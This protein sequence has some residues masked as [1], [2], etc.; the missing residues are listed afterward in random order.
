[1]TSAEMSSRQRGIVVAAGC[2]NIERSLCKTLSRLCPG[3]CLVPAGKG[4]MHDR[5]SELRPA[6]AFVDAALIDESMAKLLSTFEQLVLF[7][8]VGA[9]EAARRFR[10]PIK[11]G[12]FVHFEEHWLTADLLLEL[13]EKELTEREDVPTGFTPSRV[14][15]VRE[16]HLSPLYDAQRLIGPRLT[17]FLS[18]IRGEIRQDSGRLEH[19][20]VETTSSVE[21]PSTQ[22]LLSQNP[23][24]I[25]EALNEICQFARDPHS[26]GRCF[27]L[28]GK[29]G[30]GKSTLSYHAGAIEERLK[31]VYCVG[32]DYS[33]V[34]SDQILKGS[35]VPLVRSFARVVDAGLFDKAAREHPHHLAIDA[36]RVVREIV[37]GEDFSAIRE[38]PE[39]TL[40]ILH[41]E[42]DS[43]FLAKMYCYYMHSGSRPE[44]IA[45]QHEEQARLIRTAQDWYHG[46]ARSPRKLFAYYLNFVLS[47]ETVENLE[48]STF[49][50][51]VH[52]LLT[53]AGNKE[54]TIESIG[55]SLRKLGLEDPVLE[56]ALHQQQPGRISSCMFD[57]SPKHARVIALEA[58]QRMSRGLNPLILLDNI[59]QRPSA[60]LEA[61]VVAGAITLFR[62]HINE[63]FPDSRA[64]V[65]MRDSTY[66]Q[67]QWIRI[68][69][70][71]H[72]PMKEVRPP[73]LI[74]VLDKRCETWRQTA[75]HVG[76][77]R[78]YEFA[79][80]VIDWVKGW[81]R[82]R[83]AS[84]AES[85]EDPP[86]IDIIEARYPFNVGD[87]LSAFTK[88]CRNA[89]LHKASI[90]DASRK[91]N[92][93]PV[94]SEKS[95][96]FFLR[97]FLLA[98]R[99]YFHEEYN[100]IPNVYDAGE[101]DSPFNALVRC[102]I[103][104]M[105]P[106][107]G[108]FSPEV[109]SEELCGMGI[110]RRLVEATLQAFKHFDIVR[111]SP[112]VP[113]T[114]ILSIWGRFFR[115]RVAFDL[116]YVDIVWWITSMLPEYSLG[117]PRVRPR[118]SEL[119]PLAM[120]F[121]RWLRFEEDLALSHL[122][123]R[124]D[125]I[126]RIFDEVSYK[127]QYSLHRIEQSAYRR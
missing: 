118:A 41:A 85:R 4:P 94:W 59:D 51:C 47:V 70:E 124:T 116:P 89:L 24:D 104:Q 8:M 91:S 13:H 87:Q 2:P 34:T 42:S 60:E 77:G 23:L 30:V 54:R 69:T 80:D 99:P 84:P 63:W 26:A 93:P 50:R 110:P 14:R 71:E 113:E 62:K 112:Q 73:D 35:L 49:A 19:E 72:Y 40:T 96:E 56:S 5:L 108:C 103:L 46:L 102:W 121:L 95:L 123:G 6:W 20:F 101:P 122:V 15:S 66:E 45:P 126:P 109:F 32:I 82:D 48:T 53:K 65:C 97:V 81:R 55:E 11:N 78:D 111:D 107:A 29:S 117:S 36:E 38:V 37:S 7:N 27:I 16:Q 28:I 39:E 119:R 1:M 115:E 10:R 83:A 74:T 67:E 90:V 44:E 57:L 58:I 125:R 120:T 68:F 127:V 33:L 52:N 25:S 12:P 100:D 86:L 98:D 61:R 3:S 92:E 17:Q 114:L 75:A 9:T 22:Q 43:S 21:I 106:E 79:E 31:N 76:A 18:Y 88:C 105:M 64:I